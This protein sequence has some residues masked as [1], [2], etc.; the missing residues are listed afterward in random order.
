MYSI[1]RYILKWLGFVDVSFGT[2][3]RKLHSLRG[4]SRKL[5][6]FPDSRGGWIDPSSEIKFPENISIGN[7]CVFSQCTLG[8]KSRIS[9][10]SGVTI[11]KGAVIETGSL[12]R[13]GE[14]RHKSAPISIGD[15]VW[16]AT[17]VIILGGSTIEDDCLIS[18]GSVFS[19]HLSKG[20]IYK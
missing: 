17:N 7:N 11:S 16:I 19:G 20:S 5:Y 15:R 6:Y 14:G 10:G 8:A 9:I 3:T 13:N 1:L 18:A 12:T 4:I 2:V